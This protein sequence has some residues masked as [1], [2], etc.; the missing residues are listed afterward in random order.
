[1]SEFGIIEITRQRMRPSLKRSIY[2]DCPHCKGAGLVKTPESMSLDL[3]RRMAIAANDMKVA[4]VELAVCADVAFHMLNK[5]R[6][7][8]AD[9]EAKTAKRVV[10]RV[11]ASLGLDESR[12]ELFDARDGVVVLE[13]IGMT[14]PDRGHTTQLGIRPPGHTSQARGGRGGPPANGE[15]GG[16]RNGRGRGGD[17]DRMAPARA[18]SMESVGEN[19]VADEDD[20][21]DDEETQ[22]T[23]DRGEADVDARERSQGYDEE[24]GSRR[25]PVRGREADR[26][27]LPAMLETEAGDESAEEL[28]DE[29]LGGGQGGSD[30]PQPRSEAQPGEE[31]GGRRRRRRRRRRGRGGDQAGGNANDARGPSQAQGSPDRPADGGTG[32]DD[33]ARYAGDLAGRVADEYNDDYADA[34]EPN[35]NVRDENDDS[36]VG[37]FNDVEPADAIGPATEGGDS[38]AED[39]LNSSFADGPATQGGEDRPRRRRRRG[40]RRHR[41]QE[42]EPVAAGDSASRLDAMLPDEVLVDDAFID[43]PSRQVAEPI[44]ADDADAG[45]VLVLTDADA[46]PIGTSPAEA[47]V[48]E[49]VVDEA[50][51]EMAAELPSDEDAPAE[52]AAPAPKSRRKTAAKKVP[53]AKAP[54][55]AKVAKPK[56]AAKVAKKATRKKPAQPTAPV[57]EAAGVVSTGTADT[58]VVEADAADD[59]VEPVEPRPLARPKSY[60]DLDAI[61]DDYD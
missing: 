9:L 8:I 36:A 10:I 42:G 14:V 61:P 37:T 33:R 50:T 13:E 23:I 12:F 46:I 21:F 4:R 3:M 57:A 38:V 5:K 18:L 28:A 22:Q 48:A 53:A 31:G 29:D 27:D 30:Q 58:H 26:N 11:D 51:A 43:E 15:R 17:R 60:S 45:G 20:D 24:P 16:R 40:G 32:Q 19:D 56:A 59:L 2:F 41:R 39:D 25:P 49:A 44:L 55:A 1:M 6:A 7:A 34:D 35:G 47:A 54:K 52:P